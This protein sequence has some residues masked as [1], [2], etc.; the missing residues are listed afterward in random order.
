ML[1]IWC[2]IMPCRTCVLWEWTC[3]S[4]QVKVH[5]V[6][7][8]VRRPFIPAAHST[9]NSH[10]TMV[11]NRYA[12]AVVLSGGSKRSPPE[13][14]PNG[15][16]AAFLRGDLPHFR[17]CQTRIQ[18]TN[19]SP[20]IRLFSKATRYCNV[21]SKRLY[22]NSF[23]KYFL[24]L[25]I[26]PDFI[27]CKYDDIRTSPDALTWVHLTNVEGSWYICKNLRQQS[28]KRGWSEGRL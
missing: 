14:S 17:A 5:H 16:F 22:F 18:G 26:T 7:C 21:T 23:G 9:T 8:F 25:Q 13:N 12:S 10:L 28:L 24:G 2:L 19:Q 11:G 1:S 3:E 15:Y 4:R 6:A 20:Y 27:K